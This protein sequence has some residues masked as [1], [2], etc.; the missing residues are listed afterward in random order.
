[1]IMR[2][3]DL[4]GGALATASAALVTDAAAAQLSLGQVLALHTRAR[5]GAGALDA[6]TGVRSAIELHEGGM[7][8]KGGYLALKEGRMRVD[9]FM[10]S[11]RMYS[12]GIDSRGAWE[13]AEGKAP[14]ASAAQGAA[15][16]R[17]GV[18]Y[19]LYGLHAYPSLGHR[20]RLI[21]RERIEGIDYYVIEA[22]L[23]DGAVNNFYINPRTWMIDRTR[24]N[25]AYHPALDSGNTWVES[26]FSHYAHVRGVKVSMEGR[27]VNLHKNKV[28]ATSRALHIEY[29]SRID[30]TILNRDYRPVRTL[31]DLGFK[32]A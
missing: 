11:A 8:H 10:G 4:I 18:L 14:T 24:N 26:Q 2:R 25:R 23:S 28:L 17:H 7:N 12:E 21:G 3:R 31:Q 5:G 29:N 30:E 13:W 16:L 27:D 19:N 15:A 9:V 20:L 32:F 6:I 1:M 22:K